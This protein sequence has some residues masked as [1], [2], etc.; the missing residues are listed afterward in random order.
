MSYTNDDNVRFYIS[1][2]GSAPGGIGTS[3]LGTAAVARY[4]TWSDSIIDLMLAR[5][6]EVPFGTVYPAIESISTTL[7]AWKSLR[8]IFSNE[9]PKALAF[10]E[11][12]Y[13]KAMSFLEDLQ[14][15]S[16]DLP[17][18]TSGAIVSERGSATKVWSSN[19]DYNPTFDVDDDLDQA[20]DS[21]RLTDIE[22]NRE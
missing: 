21:D 22:S 13:K 8:S 7:S 16:A 19:M 12:D 4:I 15:G 5:R 1:A 18:G 10:V 17:T 6:Y 20:V 14:G 9:I 2:L 11:D 3:T